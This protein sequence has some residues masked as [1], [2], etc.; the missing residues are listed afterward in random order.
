MQKID[1][2]KTYEYRTRKDLMCKKEKIKRDNII[3]QCKNI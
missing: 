3:E 1:F 2:T